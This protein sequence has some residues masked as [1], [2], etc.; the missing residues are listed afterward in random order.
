[1]VSSTIKYILFC[2]YLLQANAF[3]GVSFLQVGGRASKKN[4]KHKHADQAQSRVEYDDK[5]RIFTNRLGREFNF[6]ADGVWRRIIQENPQKDNHFCFYVWHAEMYQALPADGWNR[7]KKELREYSKRIDPVEGD[8]HCEDLIRFSESQQ[9]PSAGTNVESNLSNLTNAC[10]AD[11]SCERRDP[12]GDDELHDDMVRFAEGS[13]CSSTCQECPAEKSEAKFDL[14]PHDDAETANKKYTQFLIELGGEFNID[15]HAAEERL[16]REN[17]DANQKK[18]SQLAHKE[19]YEALPEHAW[20][21]VKTAF[22]KLAQRVTPAHADGCCKF[23]ID[24]AEGKYNPS[25]DARNQCATSSNDDDLATASKKYN[26]DVATANKKYNEFLIRLGGEF[27]FDVNAVWGRIHREN[28]LVDEDSLY[29]LLYKE[30]Y[31][32]LPKHAWIRLKTAYRE[33]L[34]RF[35]PAG[36]DERLKRVINFVEGTD[37]QTSNDS[38]GCCAECC[39]GSSRMRVDE[40]DADSGDDAHTIETKYYGFLVKLAEEWDIDAKAVVQSIRNEYPQ[41]H[42]GFIHRVWH[43]VLYKMFP[44]EARNRVRTIFHQV[45]QLLEPAWQGL[46]PLEA[47]ERRRQFGRLKKGMEFADGNQGLLTDPDHTVDLSHH[48]ECCTDQGEPISIVV[49][50][51]AEINLDGSPPSSPDDITKSS[52]N[53]QKNYRKRRRQ[54]QKKEVEQLAAQRIQA[55]FKGYQTRKDLARRLAAQCIQSF[56]TSYKARKDI[57]RRLAQRDAA[58]YIQAGILGRA[59]RN[60]VKDQFVKETECSLKTLQAA[61]RGFEIRSRLPAVRDER[62]RDL[63]GRVVRQNTTIDALQQRKQELQ[64]ELDRLSTTILD[65]LSAR[66]QR[67]Q[68]LQRQVQ[69]QKKLVEAMENQAELRMQISNAEKEE[70]QNTVNEQRDTIDGLRRAHSHENTSTSEREQSLSRQLSAQDDQLNC[71]VCLAN[72]KNVVVLPCKH[73]AVCEECA[74]GINDACPVCRTPIEQKLTVFN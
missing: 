6:D 68:S 44:M 46:D 72:R 73:L 43:D 30:I 12:A 19:M 39:Q 4:R 35:I 74:L 53:T 9:G 42:L 60:D 66:E 48:P 21:R 56:F 57:A 63:E 54:K 52:N 2:S 70:L 16:G 62:L 37:A 59:T 17:P 36:A 3:S 45:L 67:E 31:Q 26:D 29:F 58:P 41:E 14:L 40:C 28:P 20:T 18:M 38:Q 10:P 11:D 34:Q 47:E 8:A 7:I 65:N 22:R 64:H 61:F 13:E 55:V 32:A 15:V 71:V 33:H 50:T 23:V 5:Y 49:N 25:P 24:S 69:D 1:M 51:T 27:D